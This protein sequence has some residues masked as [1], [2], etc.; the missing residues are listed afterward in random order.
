MKVKIPKKAKDMSD[1]SLIAGLM[2]VTTLVIA[3]SVVFSRLLIGDIK[4]NNKVIS[5]KNDVSDV[6]KQNVA[7]IP[8]LQTNFNTLAQEGVKPADILKALPISVAYADFAS[9]LEAMASLA[10]AQLTT[11]AA[12][13]ALDS[14][15]FTGTQGPIPISFQISVNGKFSEVK[16]FITNM[17]NSKR[18]IQIV[19][20]KISGTE[21]SIVGDFTVVTYYQALSTISDQTQEVAQ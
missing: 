1:N 10:G 9:D 6:L 3:A 15:A 17:Q 19:Q 5:A 2:T 21:P 7:A 13:T 11:A 16:A 8:E 12:A 20:A 14:S 4:F 18:P